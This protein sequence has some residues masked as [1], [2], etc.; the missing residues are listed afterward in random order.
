MRLCSFASAEGPRA[1]AI[2]RDGV[3]DLWQAL[4]ERD[5]A[6]DPAGP[7][8]HRTGLRALLVGH[9]A[10]RIEDA[11]ANAEPFAPLE[12]V[13]LLPPITDPPK[14]V[15]IGLNYRA[16]AAEAGLE[17]PSVPTFFA[18]FANALAAPGGRSS[19]G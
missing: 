16:H 18:K 6:L 5:G 3:V 11:A 2:R 8:L 17:P 14:I 9:Q 19:A 12:E 10:S 13:E 1:G 15:C 4:G 7:P